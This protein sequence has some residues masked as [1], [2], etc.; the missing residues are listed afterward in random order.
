MAILSWKSSISFFKL[1]LI[2]VCRVSLPHLLRPLIASPLASGTQRQPP[3]TELKTKSQ[4]D[5]VPRETSSLS[6][7]DSD[8]SSPLS[9]EDLEKQRKRKAIG[10]VSMRRLSLTGRTVKKTH[11]GTDSP[12]PPLSP[13]E[14][15]DDLP[16]LPPTNPEFLTKKSVMSSVFGSIHEDDDSA[17]E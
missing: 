12:A 14:Q 9:P 17:K 8:I 10:S 16:P 13:R 5:V 6:S 2:H 4:E 1:R 11:S 7:R 3:T 15:Q